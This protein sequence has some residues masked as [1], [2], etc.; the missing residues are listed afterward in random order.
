MRGTFVQMTLKI[1]LIERMH[2]NIMCE[3]FNTETGYYE[4][5]PVIHNTWYALVRHG[6]DEAP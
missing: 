4:N 3:S 6:R 1:E 5:A 2:N